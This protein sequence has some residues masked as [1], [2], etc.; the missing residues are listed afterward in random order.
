MNESPSDPADE[1][2]S[3]DPDPGLTGTVE[4]VRQTLSLVTGYDQSLAGRRAMYVAMDLAERLDARLRVV[5]VPDLN[6]YPI[7]PDATD[8]EDQALHIMAAQREEA[9][10]IL[11]RRPIH[12]E[13]S[14]QRGE[15]AAVLTQIAREAGALMII[16][17]APVHR[18]GSRL[19]QMLG[20]STTDGLLR[21]NGTPVLIVPE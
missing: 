16:V 20:A 3:A 10:R 19:A 6:D 7:D 9:S 5:H 18:L 14:V 11:A 2:S 15:P 13:Y 1:R 8:W 21:R 4:V 17:G 12:W